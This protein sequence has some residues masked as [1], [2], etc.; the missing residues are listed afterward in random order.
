MDTLVTQEQVFVLRLDLT[1]EG[2]AHL[3]GPPP[4][5]CQPGM[6]PYV[7]PDLIPL[8]PVWSSSWVPLRE[9]PPCPPSTLLRIISGSSLSCSLHFDRP[10][11]GLQ[12][13]PDIRPHLLP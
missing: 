6:T 9:D 5:G 3:P 8:S 2:V 11:L 10:L 12:V 1:T 7:Y 13:V 4:P